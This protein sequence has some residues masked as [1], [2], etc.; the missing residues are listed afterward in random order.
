M[1]MQ[2][3][4]R[5]NILIQI[6]LGMAIF[7]LFI[8]L[9]ILSLL[10]PT[11]T[12]ALIHHLAIPKLWILNG[13]LYEIKWSVFSYYPMNID[14]LYL[15]P[16]YFHNDIIPNFIH[17][18]F[19]IGTS[20]LIFCYLNNKFGRTWGLL[21]V[22]IFLSIPMIMRLSTVAY[23]D[24]GLIFFTTASIFAYLR[25]RNDGYS[26]NKWFLLSSITMGIALGT[27]YNALVAWFLLLS[28][29]I[30]LYSRDKKIQWPAIRYGAIFFLISLLIFSPWLI[31]NLILTGNPLF[32]LFNGFF[33]VNT[34][35]IANEGN[36]YCVVSGDA[37]MGMFKYRAMMYG[38]SFW[39]T[40]M[41]PLRFFF[42][43]Q[44][45]SD[46]YFDGVL[47]PLLIIMIPFAF[48]NK[49]FQKDKIFF[50]VFSVLFIL[51]TFFLDELRIRYILPTLP[52][53]AILTVMGIMNILI[54]SKEKAK[55]LRYFYIGAILL[56]LIILGFK[57][58]TYLNNHF[59]SLQPAKYLLN[60]ETRDEYLNRH[61][62]S[63]AAI[64][65]INKHTPQNTKVRLI[66]LAGRGYY[67][68]R[69]YEDDSSF[70]MNVIRDFVAN[71]NDDKI[72]QKYI[73]SLGCTHLLIR[74]DL[75]MKYLHDNYS[76]EKINRLLQQMGRATEIIYEANGYAVYK[77][78]FQN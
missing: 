18:G 60:M 38:E 63:Y 45:Y 20:W 10:P 66:L 9:I 28:A 59:Y 31:K 3:T 6:L 15:V 33:N 57:N 50:V 42:Q 27:K 76:P 75:Y 29:I 74:K 68:D 34:N 25:W 69:I 78:I 48:M 71:S 65:Y 14:L 55:P 54:W 44:D 4:D 49:S 1:I 22:L 46:R 8:T 39:Q 43:G 77:I 11:A 35:S 70:G 47:N 16:L 53:L 12:D 7:S 62:K 13:G 24:L 67:L 64:S 58:V 52:F 26:E 36:T 41:I 40:L 23:V 61:T 72:F 51:I 19:G 32:P 56:F 21:G 73:R 2:K 30:F 5:L 17:M 37:Y